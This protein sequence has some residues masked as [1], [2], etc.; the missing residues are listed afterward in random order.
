M[1]FKKWML[2]FLYQIVAIAAVLWIASLRQYSSYQRDG[3]KGVVLSTLAKLSPQNDRSLQAPST[4]KT[5]AIEGL[6]IDDGPTFFSAL[7]ELYLDNKIVSSVAFQ[8]LESHARE[9]FKAAYLKAFL[10]KHEDASSYVP[11][12]RWFQVLTETLAKTQSYV[13]LKTYIGRALAYVNATGE[14][15]ERLKTQFLQT[16]EA[17]LVNAIHDRDFLVALAK[18]TDRLSNDDRQSPQLSAILRLQERGLNAQDFEEIL[19]SRTLSRTEQGYLWGAVIRHSDPK[20][21][22]DWIRR[23]EHHAGNDGQL[24]IRAYAGVV[25]SQRPG[26]SLFMMERFANVAE[27]YPVSLQGELARAYWLEL[28]S[29]EREQSTLRLHAILSPPIDTTVRFA[30]LTYTPQLRRQIANALY[31]DC[32]YYA[33]ERCQD[34]GLF[35]ELSHTWKASEPK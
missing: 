17:A 19:H 27:A 13:D 30:K 29:P 12:D 26:S 9:E 14:Y 25:D 10:D 11:T 3:S 5:D 1:N 8:I 31:E 20:Q 4:D 6:P 24:L 23:V 35:A 2:L 32:Q 33:K 34:E 21:W 15:D 18:R 7:R 22:A 28:D 16:S